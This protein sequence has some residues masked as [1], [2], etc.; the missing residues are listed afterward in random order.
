MSRRTL[1]VTGG[2]VAAGGALAYFGR[3]EGG[4]PFSPR[5]RRRVEGEVDYRGAVWVPAADANWRMADRPHDFTIDRVI[6]HVTQGSHATTLKVFRDPAHQAATHYLVR[7]RDG[8]VTQLV[9]EMDVAFHAGH[10]D[11]NQ[12]SVGIEHEGWIERPEG[13]TEVMYRSSAR[14]TARVCRRYGIPV[15][16]EHIIGHVEVPDQDHVDPGKDW[17]WKGYLRMVNEEYRKLPRS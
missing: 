7:A 1:L 3:E 10:R 17:D 9:R 14:L 16:R 4:S 11:F 2:V 8:Q 5:R 13:F 15:D 12:R 6:L